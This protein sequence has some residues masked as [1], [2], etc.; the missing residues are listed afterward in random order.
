[1]IVLAAVPSSSVLLVV[2][3]ASSQ[4]TRHGVFA[5][6]GVVVGDILFVLLAVYGFAAVV[7]RWS[8]AFAL[9]QLLSG[10]YLMRL[11]YMLWCSRSTEPTLRNQ[12]ARSSLSSFGAGLM[13]TLS[14]QK[15]VFFYLAFFPAFLD[16]RAL[17]HVDVA[18]IALVTL[19]GV[20]GVK[21]AYAFFASS[22]RSRTGGS[23]RAKIAGFASV[24]LTAVGVYLVISGST[25]LA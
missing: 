18:I 2:S 19:V 1:M 21:V 3:R 24:L 25:A 22:L 23:T 11:G 10:I 16:M 8:W 4:G 12:D 7:E 17:T 20:G 9:F 15:A 5:A 14:D 6:L 13:L